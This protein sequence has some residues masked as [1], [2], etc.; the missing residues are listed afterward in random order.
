[1]G[2]E[3]QGIISRVSY[4]DEIPAGSFHGDEVP[5]GSFHSDEVPAGS[6]H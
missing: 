3:Q 2:G 6:F 1:M 5:T 4:G